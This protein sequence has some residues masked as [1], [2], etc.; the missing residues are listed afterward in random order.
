[1][2]FDQSG[3]GF[4]HVFPLRLKDVKMQGPEPDE[5]RGNYINGSG[6]DTPFGIVTKYCLS[7]L[8]ALDSSRRFQ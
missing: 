4:P 7:D 8:S 5:A 6:H 2:D 3:A 1:M